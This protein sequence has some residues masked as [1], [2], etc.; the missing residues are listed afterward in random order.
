MNKIVESSRAERMARVL[1]ELLRKKNYTHKNLQILVH[2]RRRADGS[3]QKH[4]H[5]GKRGK[6][7]SN[8]S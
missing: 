1:N 6:K 2:V 8:I 4:P 3:R 7:T 5:Q